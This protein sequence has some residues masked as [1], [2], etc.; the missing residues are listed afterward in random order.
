[1][2]LAMVPIGLLHVIQRR[3]SISLK[4]IL[5]ELVFTALITRV[6]HLLLELAENLD[7]A[8]AALPLGSLHDPLDDSERGGVMR[9]V[10]GVAFLPALLEQR[11]S[12]DAF[13]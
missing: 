3:I 2:V 5:F 8:F 11:R 1:M 10:P 9:V 6:K 7:F 12:R 13:Q 4:L